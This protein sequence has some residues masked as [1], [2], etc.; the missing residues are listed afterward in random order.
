MITLALA[1]GEIRRRWRGAAA[2][3]LVLGIGFAAVLAAAAGARRTETAFPRMLKT[4][5]ATQ[6]LVGSTAT[7]PASQQR[8]Y[9][10]VAALDGVARIARV[11]GIALI[12]VRVPKG[13]GTTIDSCAYL[14]LDGVFGYDLDRPNV[15]DG[16]LPRRDRSDEVLVTKSFAD[17]FGVGVGDRLDFASQSDNGA[18]V[19]GSTTP[20]DGPVIHATVVGVGARASEIVPVSDLDAAPSILVPPALGRRYLPDPATWCFDAGVVAIKA[21]ADVGRVL[22]AVNRIGGATGGALV[23]NRA[24]NYAD[25]NRAIR[26]QVSAL[27]LFAVAT[28]LA[29]LLVVA[30]LL[31]RQLRQAATT[32]AAVWRALGVTRSQVRVLVAA[33]SIVAAVVGGATALAGAVAVSSRFP[34]GPA[35]LAETH[36]GTQLHVAI[37]LGGAVA[38]AAAALA[39]GMAVA[40]MAQR[41]RHKPVRI[42]WL[43]RI[44]NGSSRPSLRVGVHLATTSGGSDAGVPVRSAA[45]GAALVLAAV[46]ATMSFAGGLDDLIS[47]PSRYGQDWDLMVDGGFSPVA[48]AALLKGL[49]H[50]PAVAALAGG[51]YGEVT[52]NGVGVPTVGLTD[53]VGATFPAIIEGRTPQHK[54]EIVLGLRSLRGLRRSIGDTV[55]VDTGRGPRD[56]TVVGTAAFPR[57]NR[58]SFSTLG[59]GSGAMIRTSAFPPYDHN[60]ADLP[61]TIHPQDLLSPAGEMLEFLT[62]RTRPGTTAAV[63]RGVVARAKQIADTTGAVLRTE[64]RPIA[65]DNYAAVRSTPLILAGLLGLMAAATLAHLVVSVVRRRRRDLALCAALGMRRAQVL[66]AV[67]IQALLVAN[68][69]LLVGLP[70]GLAAGRVAWSRFASDLGVVDTIRLP[71]GALALVV[72]VVEVVAGAVAMVPAIVAARTRPAVALRTE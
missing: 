23:Q 33:P 19:A 70:L 48:V 61:P 72:P 57:L 14:S 32:S 49:A 47:T 12:P 67:V 20:A 7:I 31:G 36:R 43:T 58:G 40:Y 64:Q 10:R 71:L 56:M 69:A 24:A 5:G 18:L 63:V 51:R 39:G 60:F 37:H 66:R 41:V 13:A 22:D 38:V 2:V 26:P 11:A 55:K 8:F 45:A 30:Q 9:K 17:T 52:V 50:D 34:I 1:W 6:L 29:T 42:G 44:G 4:T 3:G 53:L 59:L 21:G 65:I 25:V 27:W 15:L 35:R 28:A 62:I 16:R 46:V 68:A 54:D